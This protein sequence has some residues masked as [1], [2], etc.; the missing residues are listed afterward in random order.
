MEQKEKEVQLELLVTMVQK[1]ILVIQE[2]TE[3]QE[4]QVDEELQGEMDTM[5]P[6]ENAEIQVPQ[7]TMEEQEK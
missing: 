3:L 1:G 5:V 7:D 2:Q 4:A 6:K